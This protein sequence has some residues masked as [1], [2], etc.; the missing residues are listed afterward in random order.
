MENMNDEELSQKL[1]D[2]EEYENEEYNAAYAD[3][4][5]RQDSNLKNGQIYYSQAESAIL[6]M[7]EK[8]GFEVSGYMQTSTLSKE[9]TDDH[10][11]GIFSIKRVSDGHAGKMTVDVKGHSS[12]LANLLIASKDDP[13]PGFN[14]FIYGKETH[15]CNMQEDKKSWLLFRRDEAERLFEANKQSFKTTKGVNGSRSHKGFHPLYIMPNS[16]LKANLKKF[17]LFTDDGQIINCKGVPGLK[18]R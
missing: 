8:N 17:I 16:W 5:A 12:N 11:D 2:A 6:K 15:I 13:N 14:N 3:K 9:D 18:D 4:I 7:L 1:A 10:I